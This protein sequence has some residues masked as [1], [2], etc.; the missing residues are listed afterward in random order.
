M[1]LQSPID[2]ELDQDNQDDLIFAHFSKDELS[3]MDEMQGGVSV[4]P[5]KVGNKSI[6]VREYSKLGQLIENPEIREVFMDIT[7]KF[8]TDPEFSKNAPDVSKDIEREKGGR[9]FVHVE[10]ESDPTLRH[11]AELGDDGDN[12]IALI[13]LNLAHLLDELSGGP[14]VNENT[15]FREYKWFKKLLGIAAPIIGALVMGPAGLGMGAKL[16]I[17]SGLLSTGLG[18]AMGGALGT[19]LSTGSWKG[20]LGNAALAGGTA[21]LAHGLFNGFGAPAASGTSAQGALGAT[22]AATAEAAKQGAASGVTSASSAPALGSSSTS[23]IWDTLVSPKVL[24]PAAIGSYMLGHREDK[25][26][27]DR[28]KEHEHNE[29]KKISDA[30]RSYH[31]IG[32]PNISGSY[33][34]PSK[35]EAPVSAFREYRAGGS[36]SKPEYVK[37]PSKSHYIQ[38]KGKGQDDL[39]Y[40]KVRQNDFILRA[41]VVSGLGDGSS[42]AGAKEL[43]SFVKEIMKSPYYHKA[44]KEKTPQVDVA[45]SDGEFKFEQAAV[46]AVGKGST[47]H[48][49]KLFRKLMFEVAKDKASHDGSLPKKAKSVKEYLYG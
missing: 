37:F 48:G 40:G 43:D 46:T 28:Q 42:K 25:R 17:G 30:L 20:S 12:E 34:E 36:V 23:P 15:S 3:S 27:E 11:L 33:L 39:I 21:S 18:G 31:D 19:K 7:H 32:A 47:D 4:R 10:S 8:L 14:H 44:K 49:A 9:S 26:E 2:F 24:L 35:Y 41:D 6:D 1:K 5:V 38:G 16:G 29:R 13:P 22:G 45:L